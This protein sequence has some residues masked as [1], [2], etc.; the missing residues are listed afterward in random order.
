M[1]FEPL[2]KFNQFLYR[3]NLNIF[4]FLYDWG[5]KSLGTKMPKKLPV[6][7]LIKMRRAAKLDPRYLL[8]EE[9]EEEF[10]VRFVE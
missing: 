6:D 10:V 5:L 2:I 8:E 9:S 7:L 1:I 3:L 4:L